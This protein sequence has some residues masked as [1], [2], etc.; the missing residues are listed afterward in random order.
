MAKRRPTSPKDVSPDDLALELGTLKLASSGLT[1]EDGQ[2]LGMEFLGPIAT[3]N[4]HPS[5]DL[6]PSLKIPYFDP[7]HPD[8]P[9]RPQSGW[10]A[11]YRLRYLRLPGTEKKGDIRYTNEP[12]AGVAAYFPRVVDWVDIFQDTDATLMITEGELKAAK[13]CVAGSPCIGL[14]GVW[15]FRGKQQGLMLLP[16]LEAVNWVKRRVYLVY[17]SDVRYKTGVQE[18]MNALA[19]ELM[20]RGALPFVIFLPEAEDGSL[21]QGLDDYLVNN[22]GVGVKE[23]ADRRQPLTQVRKLYDLNHKLIYVADPGLIVNRVTDQKLSPALFRETYGNV[24]YAEMTIN[25]EGE[26]SLKKAPIATSWMKWPI[27]ADAGRLTYQPGAPR[28]IEH[29]NPDLT[30]WN[31]WKGWGCEPAEGNVEPFLT[32]I[33]HLFKGSSVE[34]MQWF[35]RWLAYPLQF[36]GTK[37]FSAAVIYGIHHGTGKSLVGYTMAKIYGDNF[38]EISAS[39]LHNGF[40]GWAENKQFVMGD[41]VSGSDKRSDNDMLKKLITQKELRV[42]AK[43]MPEYSVPDYINYYLTSNHPDAF[44]LEDKDRRFFIH[45][46]VSGMMDEAFYMDY[47]L[48]LDTEGPAAVFDY[49][50]KLDLGNFNPA[51]PARVT[52]A[53]ISMTADTQSDIGDWVRRLRDDPDQMLMVGDCP[54]VGDLFT[55]GQLKQIYDPMEVKKVTA[56]GLGREL[57][58]AGFQRVNNGQP[59][60]GPKGT[61]RYFIVRNVE[62]WVEATSLEV[63]RYLCDEVAEKKPKGKK[64]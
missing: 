38:T 4:L 21:K 28:F 46:V 47:I 26:V 41:D 35:L 23:L 45:E 64:Y 56:N 27:R 54:M 8:Q 9:L 33:K 2:N 7:L 55:T 62:K 43:F 37:M 6:L 63:T 57:R 11:F 16:E 59:V 19:E 17:D 30:K 48:W 60:R 61:D 12:V 51:A 39:S 25:K 3:T 36:P 50:L 31:M 18:A 22:P 34:D 32:L 52:N 20:L 53:K 10:P 42:N 1:L 5:F 29:E 40:N 15:N 49:L 13:A 58:R 24:D 44:Y 14:G